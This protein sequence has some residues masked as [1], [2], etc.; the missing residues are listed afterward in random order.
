MLRKK[1]KVVEG[2][3][4]HR[5][6]LVLDCRQTNC[7]FRPPP[8]TH[9]G[10]LASIAETELDQGST[11]YIAGADIRDCFYAVRMEP[12][13]QQYFALHSDLSD[14]EIQH[15]TSGVV[16]PNSGKHVPVISVLPMGFSWSFYLVQQLHTDTALNALGLPTSALFLDGQPPPKLER[17]RLSI[18]PYCDN[19]HCICL[20]RAR[21][22]DGED[23]MASAL[24]RI[25]FELHEH[26]EATD[27]FETLGGVIDGKRGLVHTSLKKLWHLIYAFELA[28]EVVVSTKTIQRLVGHAMVAC[29][30]NRNG[31]AVCRHLYDF[32]SSD[33][34]PRKLLPSERQE[35]RIFAGL[36][37][38]L[39][40]DL[41][42][43]WSSSV[44]CSDASP[45]G[46]GVCEREL[47]SAV[48][49]S[50]G[51]W[52]ERWRFKRLPASEWKPRIRSEG[53]D[54]FR[55]VE[56]VTGN[57]VDPSHDEYMANIDFPEIPSSL[58]EPSKWTTVM[59]GKWE[60]TAEHITMKEAR[61]LLLAVRRLSRSSQHR[62]KRHLVLVDNL[63]LCFAVAKGRA[64]NF[65]LLRVIQ[66]ISALCLATNIT[67]R[68][69]WVRSELNVADGPSRGFIKPGV[70]PS[71]GKPEN[72]G[73]PISEIYSNQ[74][75]RLQRRLPG[76]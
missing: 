15:V 7:L 3:T 17:D 56:T 34:L 60:H 21:C 55:G 47:D 28:A 57:R 67:I 26:V 16:G 68:P 46:Y 65:D 25:G 45:F 58:M 64:H 51:R 31:M 37:P 5:Q 72:K 6:R 36:V 43:P 4:I 8:Q 66:R 27:Y 53:W 22:Q 41:R 19:L 2:V 9:L 74:H 39:V 33:G 1:P 38:L 76:L 49:S 35:C 12:G 61:S 63:A 42:R 44:T 52:I 69:R 11:M 14:D 59:M 24:E 71:S 62:S 18:M 30:L 75:Q 40:S 10:S 73:V 70:A 20:D 32:I 50:H 48:A 23:A 13:L 29:V 54:V